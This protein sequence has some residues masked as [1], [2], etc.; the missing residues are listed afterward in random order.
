MRD[1]NYTKMHPAEHRRNCM[2]W[3]LANPR[4][5]YAICS[6][7]R[8]RR[9]TFGFVPLNSPFEGCVGH[10][11]NDHDVIYIPEELHRSIFHN[12][13]AGQGMKEINALAGQYLTEDWT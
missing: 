1:A 12:Q 11:I 5:F 6:K 10:H 7:A 4:V 8:A 3:R 9:R 13:T 2:A